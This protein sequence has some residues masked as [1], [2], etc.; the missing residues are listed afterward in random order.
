MQLLKLIQLYFYVCEVYDAKLRSLVHRHTKNGLAPQFTDQEVLTVYLFGVGYEKRLQLKELHR[1]MAHHYADCFPDLPSYE[2]F[3]QRL[4]R[5]N[6]VFA[7]LLAG[8]V[9][10]WQAQ[11]R[12]GQDELFLLTDS[13]PIVT[14]S[15]RRYGV[16]APEVTDKGFNAAKKMHFWGVKLH[17]ISLSIKGA[18]PAVSYLMVSPASEH[19]LTAQRNLLEENK[20][21]Y[22]FADKAFKDNSLEDS[23]IAAGGKLFIPIK[24]RQGQSVTDKQRHRAADDLYSKMV[25][26]IRQPIESFFGWLIERTDIQRAAKVRS[27]KGLLVHIFGKITAAI[28][29]RMDELKLI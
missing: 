24:Q 10:K 22:A 7:P 11:A 13:M 3:N 23:F 4:N 27:T 29:R 14:C 26:S 16:V 12:A 2:A 17:S 8:L 21:T 5:L 6:P 15:G 28:Y 18:L 20:D 9:M 1:C 19:D 25:S